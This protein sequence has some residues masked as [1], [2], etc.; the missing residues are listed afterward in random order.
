M[1]KCKNVDNLSSANRDM[2]CDYTYTTTKTCLLIFISKM[3]C[4]TW[5]RAL[6]HEYRELRIPLP[7]TCLLIYI[8]KMIIMHNLVKVT[9]A[10]I[11]RVYRDN[12]FK[13]TTAV[14]KDKNLRSWPIEC[15][16][17]LPFKKNMFTYI[18]NW[19]S[20]SEPHTCDFNATFSLYLYLYMYI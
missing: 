3:I 8:S 6:M 16:I 9:H 18:N 7:K 4:I 1:D 15:I 20:V 5:S 2:W 19:A 14:D 11:Q 12:K 10:C 13:V 17:I